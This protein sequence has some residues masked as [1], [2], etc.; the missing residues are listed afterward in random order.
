VLI[1][2][3]EAGVTPLTVP[4]L[5]AGPHT[6]RIERAGYVPITTTARIEAR[7]RARVAVT[8]TAERPR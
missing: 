3:A 2:G 4:A 6:V 8:L 5:A 7:T 1:D